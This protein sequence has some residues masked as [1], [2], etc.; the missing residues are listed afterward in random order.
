MRYLLFPLL[1]VFQIGRAQS[2]G[3]LNPKIDAKLNAAFKCIND[4]KCTGIELFVRECLTESQ[5]AGYETGIAMAYNFLGLVYRDNNQLDSA[6]VYFNKSVQLRDK[7]G[8]ISES[9]NVLR[10][11]ASVYRLKGEFE[12]ALKY[13]FDALKRHE[14]LEDPEVY[15]DYLELA[16]IYEN[17]G[18]F[19]SSNSWLLKRWIEDPKMRSEILENARTSYSIAN[20]YLN[21]NLDSA[22]TF[23]RQARVLYEKADDEIGVFNADGIVADIHTQQSDYKN[24]EILYRSMSD[25]L[26]TLKSPDS[27][28]FFSFYNNYGNFLIKTEKFSQALNM[29]RRADQTLGNPEKYPAKAEKLALNKAEVFV[30]LHQLDSALFYQME[31]NRFAGLL[32]STEKAKSIIQLG[33][34]KTKSDLEQSTFQL[35]IQ[36][37]QN[38]I[39]RSVLGLFLI[40]CLVVYIAWQRYR[41]N[42]IISRQQEH[43]HFQEVEKLIRN[44][45]LQSRTLLIHRQDKERVRLASELH[46]GV[47]GALMALLLSLKTSR[48]ADRNV[49]I[50]ALDQSI[51]TIDKTYTDIR[52]I[53]HEMRSGEL[54][55]L[56]IQ[57]AIASLVHSVNERR[58]IAAQV[59]FHGLENKIQ[60][61]EINNHL[62]RIT[63]ELIT[64]TLKHAH[65]GEANLQLNRFPH[66]IN[67]VYEDDGKGFHY[68]SPHAGIG[69]KSIEDRVHSIGGTISIDTSPGKGFSCF[70][71]IPFNDQLFTLENYGS[72][73]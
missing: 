71:N 56:D 68:P 73:N 64:N 10:N 31:A 5:I 63:Q 28:L 44:E 58:E 66:E 61:P 9:A 51:D 7:L 4:G 19:E 52:T 45:E 15:N 16:N 54:A 8:L 3:Q 39:L 30:N 42:I 35:A 6:L 29:L 55:R 43:L 47:G 13:S 11:M 41:K 17:E 32:Y 33:T 20:N 40:A 60:D 65:A 36:N 59:Y 23:A 62:Y 12:T 48:K 21:I 53:S 37:R 38:S 18:S 24:G 34:E 50:E 49:M 1:L 46:E 14:L 25:R 2:S 70:I 26:K 27:L 22:L 69:I 57:A 72:A 67:L